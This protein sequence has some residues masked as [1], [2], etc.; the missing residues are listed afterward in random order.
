MKGISLHYYELMGKTGGH[1]GKQYLMVKDY[2]L[3]KVLD[4]IKEITV[5]YNMRVWKDLP[6]KIIHKELT[7][8][9]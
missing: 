8:F 9:S 6:E 2:M 5:V 1:E 4:K 3:G 7:L